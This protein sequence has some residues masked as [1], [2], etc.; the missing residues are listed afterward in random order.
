[1]IPEFDEHGHLP[2]GIHEATIDEVIERFS[3]PRSRIRTSRTKKL[4]AFYSF[5]KPHIDK[6]YIDGSYTT[7]KLAPDDVDI[8]L[9]FREHVIKN[10]R[11]QQRFRKF[12]D[13]DKFHLQIIF[14]FPEDARSLAIAV[15][16]VDY[17]QKNDRDF[18]PPVTKGII[19]VRS[20][21]D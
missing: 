16:H 8:V 10:L 3:R 11:V 7:N 2:P 9:F 6:L 13:K 17:F 5:I 21:N 18:D 4:R 1:M 12:L 15:G 14:A 20:N 19:L